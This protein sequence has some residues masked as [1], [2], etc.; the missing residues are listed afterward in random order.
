M[1]IPIIDNFYLGS[2]KPLDYRIVVDPGE[3]K[4]NIQHKYVGLRIW[5]VD[6]DKAYVWKASQQWEEE[7]P[8]S[9]INGTPGNIPKLTGTQ[10]IG[11]SI[12]K[13]ENGNIVIENGDFILENGD[14]IGDGSNLVNLN[15]SNITNGELS[16]DRIEPSGATS[17]Q[18]MISSNGNPWQEVGLNDISIGTSINVEIKEHEIDG[19]HYVLLAFENS[20]SESLYT[21]SGILY[22]TDTN[23]LSVDKLRVI[24]VTDYSGDDYKIL[25]RKNIG[26]SNGEFHTTEGGIIP[27]GGIIIWSGTQVP[28]KWSLCNG[29]TVNGI[30]TP[31]L[32]D[33]FVMGGATASVGNTGGS[34]S[35]DHGGSTENHTLTKNEIPAH[36]HEYR[37][38]YFAEINSQIGSG[39]QTEVTPN[40][41]GSGDSDTDNNRFLYKDDNTENNTTTGGTDN[42]HK[43]NIT[44]SSNLPP[45]YKLAYIMFTG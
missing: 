15:A 39:Y 43:H 45:Y 24:G 35:H 30:T 8:N 32:V 22:D 9:I 37:D 38:R 6:D 16:I 20:S 5:D 29:Q 41:F 33:K 4:N 7:L 36:N 25:I 40:T 31:D 17:S 26:T 14:F 18:I 42:P 23:T 28:S 12:M 13:E 21:S 27:L 19:D 11:D 10:S 34:T 2:S 3:D 44:T 1:A